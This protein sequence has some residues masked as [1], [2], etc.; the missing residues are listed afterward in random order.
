MTHWQTLDRARTPDNTDLTLHKAGGDFHILANGRKLM[1]SDMH[2]SEE[3]LATLGCVRARLLPAP[4]VLVG[5]LGMGFTLRA[6]LDVLPKGATVVTAELLAAVVAWNRTTLGALAGHPLDDPRAVVTEGDIAALLARSE[7]RFD[8]I[9][10]DVDNGPRAFTQNANTSLYSDAGLAAAH[11][12][13][14]TDGVLAV[15]SA[16]D[17]RKFEHRLRHAGF[18]VNVRHV[19]AR[20]KM[21]G[22]DHTI[23]LG[24]RDDSGEGFQPG[25]KG[26]A[27]ASPARHTRRPSTSHKRTKR[28]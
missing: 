2:G 23:F 12:A 15:W 14:H 13:L 24:F 6:A 22:P 10:L 18:R 9:L 1:S 20:L 5:G 27:P 21:G 28:S 17:D 11:A 3:A 16:W 25:Y 26:R 4:I 8:A 19:P 7:G